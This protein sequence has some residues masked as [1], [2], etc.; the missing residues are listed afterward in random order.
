MLGRCNMQ[1]ELDVLVVSGV[2][3]L[4]A[5]EN[6]DDQITPQQASPDIPPLQPSS[7]TKNR[8]LWSGPMTKRGG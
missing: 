7:F 5:D 4:E 2:D 3:N 8:A 1:W 6:E